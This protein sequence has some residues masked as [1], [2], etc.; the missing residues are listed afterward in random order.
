MKHHRYKTV[1]GLVR[2]TTGERFQAFF[3]KSEKARRALIARYAKDPNH[4][5]VRELTGTVS[6]VWPKNRV[7][8]RLYWCK[9]CHADMTPPPHE[10]N[11]T[12]KKSR[13]HF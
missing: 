5:H 4:K 6:Q 9:I 10:K 3:A 13:S 11:T 2:H 12:N 8:L 7:L 1:A